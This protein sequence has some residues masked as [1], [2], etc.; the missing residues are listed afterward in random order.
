MIP[1]CAGICYVSEECGGEYLAKFST[2]GDPI[3]Q[4]EAWK[5]EKG[6]VS[7]DYTMCGIYFEDA[8]H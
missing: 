4:N 8:L 6:T 3:D 7:V 2:C 1:E 5:L